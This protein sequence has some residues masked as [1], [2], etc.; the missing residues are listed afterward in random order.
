MA[1]FLIAATATPPQAVAGFSLAPDPAPRPQP[2]LTSAP[3]HR[4]TIAP[5]A[6]SSSAGTDKPRGTIPPAPSDRTAPPSVRP[7]PFPAST[8]VNPQ[9]IHPRG[10]HLSLA[11]YPVQRHTGPRILAPPLTHRAERDRHLA[12]LPAVCH[13]HPASV[14]AEPGVKGSQ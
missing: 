12:Q 1:G 11:P 10:I 4:H 2:R 3:Q 6:G 13:L 8:L 7:C 9:H 14:V 5:P